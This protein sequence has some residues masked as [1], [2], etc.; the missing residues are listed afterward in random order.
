MF[1]LL[2]FI[3]KI[4]ATV[5]QVKTN[6]YYLNCRVNYKAFFFRSFLFFRLATFHSRMRLFRLRKRPHIDIFSDYDDVFF[7]V[8]A[9]LKLVSVRVCR[10]AI[11][12]SDV[13]YRH[14]TIFMVKFFFGEQHNHLRILIVP[15]FVLLVSA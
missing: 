4:S 3:N 2:K 7:D 9:L 13:E 6:R 11:S 5:K 14:S 10:E 15:F 12:S 1:L 8:P